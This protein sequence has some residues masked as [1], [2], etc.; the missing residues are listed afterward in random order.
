MEK[1]EGG[2][3]MTFN[4]SSTANMSIIAADPSQFDTYDLIQSEESLLNQ[5]YRGASDEELEVAAD[6]D[7]LGFNS[8]GLTLVMPS[9]PPPGY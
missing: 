6:T 9:A 5:P 2:A 7:S 8:L 3:F 1:Q 4:M